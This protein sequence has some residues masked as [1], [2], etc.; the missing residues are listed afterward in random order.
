MDTIEKAK[1]L[2]ET[3]VQDPRCVRLQA[4]RAAANTDMELQKNVQAWNE[5]K[6]DLNKALHNLPVDRSKLMDM[7]N[8]L[9]EDYDKL[10]AH[11]LMAELHTAQNELNDLLMQINNMMQRAVSGDVDCGGSCS[12][13]SGCH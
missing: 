1:E 13:C 4:A 12:N 10:M 11:P 2:V 7:Q 9:S 3:I 8:K 6:A 5:Q